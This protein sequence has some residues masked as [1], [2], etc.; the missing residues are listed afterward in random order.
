MAIIEPLGHGDS[1]EGDAI[2]YSRRQ[3]EGDHNCNPARGVLLDDPSQGASIQHPTSNFLLPASCFPVA[4]N[5]HERSQCDRIATAS[6]IF[7]RV[8][9]LRMPLPTPLGTVAT[10]QR[11]SLAWVPLGLP[12]CIHVFS[13]AFT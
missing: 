12:K 5:S 11:L 3:L 4:S 13:R 6:R 1:L 10:W 9:R 7:L 2:E 8:L